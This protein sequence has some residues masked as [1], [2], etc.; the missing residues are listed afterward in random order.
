LT[1]I[2]AAVPCF[3]KGTRILTLAGEV[4]VEDLCIGDRVMTHDQRSLPIVWLG[5]RRVNCRHHPNPRTVWP[6]R[7]AAGAFGPCCPGRDLFLSPDHAVF[8]D[9]VLIPVKH[10]INGCTIAQVPTDAVTYY[11]VELPAHDV[12]LAE[13]LPAESY[14]DTGDHSNFANGGGSVTL[15]PNFSQ[16][17]WEAS[18]CAPLVVT[19]PALNSIRARLDT[20]AKPTFSRILA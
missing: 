13:G 17:T 14:L 20:L 4:A 5:R 18:G 10:L 3:A 15:H 8:I 1:T 19:G 2:A 16:L 6:V 12:L 11:H 9:D 7:I